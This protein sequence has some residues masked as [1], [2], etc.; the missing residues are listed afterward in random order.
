MSP[1]TRYPVPAR[2][3]RVEERVK[4]SRFIATVER[5]STVEEAEAFID[6]VE[7]EFADATH[8]CWAYA[9]GPPGSTA[10]IGMSGAGEPHGTAGRPMLDAVLHGGVGDIA[11]VVTRYFGGTELGTGGL[12]RAYGG[13]VKRALESL[14]RVERIEYAA[15]RVRI[16]YPVV[17][18]VQRLVREHEGRVVDEHYGADVRFRVEVPAGRLDAFRSELMDATRGAA[19]VAP[20]G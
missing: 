10:R 11:V 3:H 9:V 16:G 6:G 13:I 19:E 8:N 14:P 7:A 2:R 5:A 20:D 4:H 17:D 15:L 1:D 12:V 18:A